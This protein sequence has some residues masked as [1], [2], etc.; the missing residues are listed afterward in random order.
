MM[1]KYGYIHIA[2]EASRYLAAVDAFRAEGHEPTWE[3]TQVSY[4]P[5]VADRDRDLADH[6]NAENA[7]NR[8]LDDIQGIGN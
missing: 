3:A 6:P 5:E 1:A 4:K 2:D 7:L 8:I